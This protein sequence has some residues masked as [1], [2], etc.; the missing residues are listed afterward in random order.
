MR[1]PHGGAHHDFHG[2]NPAAAFLSKVWVN[3]ASR[4]SD[5]CARTCACWLG[6]E[7]IDDAVD[8]FGALEV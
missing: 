3:T 7:R 1:F 2:S 5:S 4:V 6:G 8:C